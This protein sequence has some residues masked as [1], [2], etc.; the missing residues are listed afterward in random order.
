MFAWWDA[1]YIP[2]MNMVYKFKLND[3]TGSYMA[4][5]LAIDKVLDLV[6]MHSWRQV[7][8]CTDSL[9]CLPLWKTPQFSLF[10]STLSKLNQLVT[11]LIYKIN[12]INYNKHIIRFTWCPAQVGKYN[13]KVV[14]MGGKEAARG[15]ELLNNFIN[16]RELMSSFGLD[17]ANIDNQFLLKEERRIGVGEYYLNNFN[18]IKFKFLRRITKNKKDYESL[19]RLVTGYSYTRAYLYKMRLADSL[20]YKCERESQDI[21]HVFWSCPIIVNERNKMYDILRG[22]KLLDPFSIEYLLGNLNKKIAAIMLK[23]IKMA[24]L[25]LELCL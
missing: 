14:L 13:E 16:G 18:D 22:L 8:I 20:L 3:V 6:K 10:P 19:I 5:I 4:E 17:Y 25:K 12:K 2:K 21:N 9:S 23:Y 11:D 15:G 1:P 7:N 24:N